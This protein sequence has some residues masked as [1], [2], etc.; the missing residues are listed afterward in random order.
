MKQSIYNYIIT[1]NNKTLIYNI[2]RRSCV[3]L[4][5]EE[6]NTFKSFNVKNTI[7]KEFYKLGFWIDDDVNE[8]D[9]VSNNLYTAEQLNDKQIYKIYTTIKC[10]AHC[11]YCFEQSN[12]K[13]SNNSTN[14]EDIYNF[15]KSKLSNKTLVLVFFG[16]EPLMNIK[17]INELC[18]KLKRDC[19]EAK[20]DFY[21]KIISNGYL[22][23]D[24]IIDNAI[25]I[26]N[27]KV[28]QISL[29]G[30]NDYYEKNKKI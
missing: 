20:I 22:F 5:D 29:D 19:E 8:L 30:M 7:S 4:N 25:N 23:N 1:K 10:N 2:L 16:G 21:S 6:Y 28:V 13:N 18:S 24:S 17:L 14:I 9:I 27:L 3:I 11:Y 15:I 26:W 12:I